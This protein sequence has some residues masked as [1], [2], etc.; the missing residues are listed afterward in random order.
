VSIGLWSYNPSDFPSLGDYI[1]NIIH[2][3]VW[4]S[5]GDNFIP[6][7]KHKDVISHSYSPYL[8]KGNDEEERFP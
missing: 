4:W 2:L 3:K 8:M 7:F 6:S 1:L 5:A